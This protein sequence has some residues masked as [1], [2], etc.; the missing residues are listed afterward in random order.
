MNP[1]TPIPTVIPVLA[2]EDIEAALVFYA[3]LGF[4]LEFSIPDA[5]GRLVHAHLCKGGS[6]IFLGR[7]EVSHYA[8]QPRA[9]ALRNSRPAERGMGITLILQVDD[10]TPIYD[11]V[12]SQ[13]L[14]VLAEPQDEY[15]GDRVFFF[16]DPFGYEWK[17]SQPLPP[18]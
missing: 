7:K 18:Q 1:A 8:G 14:E 16:L 5:T 10:L 11:F 9:E 12:R 17:V 6:V 4:H 3:Q 2:V 15:Y 13:S